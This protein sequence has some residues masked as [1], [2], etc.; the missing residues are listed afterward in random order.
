MRRHLPAILGALFGLLKSASAGELKP[1]AYTDAFTKAFEP[2][3][4][5]EIDDALDGDAPR[6]VILKFRVSELG[7]LKIVSGK[8]CAADPFVGT[9]AK[10]FL[11]SV[12]VGAFPVRLAVVAGT[13][14]D[15]RVAF[16]R[17]DFTSESVTAWRMALAEGDDAA[18]LGP[19]EI[20]GYPVDSGTGS[21]FDPVAGTAALE[22]M[23][24]DGGYADRWLKAGHERG[25]AE[26]GGH[27]FR[28][29]ADV[30]PA[31]IL[32]FDSGWGDGVY[33]SWFGFD[34]KGRVA[35]LVT[36]F[37]AIDWDRAKF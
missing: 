9:G 27:G 13:L 19:G 21:F 33:A 30:G 37:Q 17:V 2:G 34:A 16:A 10:P 15:G 35:A 6:T 28:L 5:A 8:L 4:F 3:W 22:A 18:S 32:A 12:P 31:N 7:S 14:G 29:I 11:Q 1:P 23:K 36:D 20:M 26:R 24:Q 25:K